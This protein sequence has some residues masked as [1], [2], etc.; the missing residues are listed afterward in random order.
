MN[1]EKTSGSLSEPTTAV[2]SKTKKR[3]VKDPNAP[4]LPLTSYMEFSLRERPKILE[5]L[6]PKSTVDIGRELGL[7]WRSLTQEEKLPF[8]LKAKENKTKYDL[9][10][11]LYKERKKT[12]R[13]EET[14]SAVSGADDG[15]V[16][17]SDNSILPSLNATDLG[18]AKQKKYSWH[19]ALKVGMLAKG[20]RVKVQFFGTGQTGI[21]DAKNWVTYS[22]KTESRIKSKE[23]MKDVAFRNGPRTCILN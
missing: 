2:K 3:R 18:F 11:K 13:K 9:E 15:T 1:Q 17:N 14:A 6:G 5:D 12:D 21:V 8:E 7:R 19:P 22:V 16:T 10:K 23:L 4:K 20:T